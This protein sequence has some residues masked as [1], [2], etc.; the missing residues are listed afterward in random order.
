MGKFDWFWNAMGAKSA[1]HEKQSRKIVG[2]AQQQAAD[3]DSLS[4]DKLREHARSSVNPSGEITDKST[5]LAALATA[6]SR[7][8]GLRPYDVQSQ[9]VLRLLTGDVIHM[10]TGEGKTLV[11][12]MAATGFALSGKRVHVVTVNDYLARRDAEWMRPLVESFGLEVAAVTES[13]DTA[14]RRQAYAADVVYAPVKEL[15]FDVLR[16]NQITSREQAVFQQADVALV[17]EA[18]SVLVD[19]A[20]VPLVLAGTRADQATDPRVTTVVANLKQERDYT[21][22][23]D[24]RTVFLTDDGAATVEKELGIDSLY[25]DEHIG[26]TLVR[27]NLALHAKALLIRDIHYLV[28]DGELKL[29]DTAKGRV[30]DLQRWPDGL[31]AAVE[32]KEGLKVTEGGRILDTL[33]IQE[34]MR[35]YPQLCGMTGTAVEATDQLRE[36]YGLYVS[37]IAPN[38]APQRFDEADRVYATVAEKTQALLDE[39]ELLHAQKQPVLIG[40]QDVA[41]SESLDAALTERGINAQVLN[42]KN[43]AEEA[44]IIAEAGMPGRVTVST[45]MAGRG[46]DIKLGGTDGT[47]YQE[48]K[49]AGG[50][51]VLGTT[52]HRSSRLDNQLRGRAGRQGDPGLSLFF[53]SLED[54]VVISGGAGESV[55]AQ[56][57]GN[58]RI[59]SGRIV[60]FI[61]HCQRVTEAQLLEIHSQTWKYNKLLADQREIIDERRSSLLDTDKAWTELREY[62]PERA[63]ELVAAGLADDVLVQAS[64]EIM[65]YHLDLAWA[66]HLEHM[67]D[68]RE[69]IH[70]RAIARETPID[71]YHRIAVREFKEIVRRGVEAARE[72][73]REVVIDNAGAHLSEGG[74]A[75]PSATW[76]YMVSDNPLAGSGN[77]ALSGI[78]NLFR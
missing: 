18:D 1:K 74:L 49:D 21:I 39:I 47:H 15:G 78:G 17:D 30:A 37:E 10:A 69:S 40:T 22:G 8:L 13:M 23:T 24:G 64:R 20:L 35:R 33:T 56:P 31:Q 67:D 41:E 54:D 50:L 27:V 36:F 46:T 72:S 77:S 34:L 73:F 70:L 14:Q 4:D 43:D 19:E 45:Q 6:S 68:V 7:K 42:A 28:H 44:A 59:D 75:R 25:S 5:F 26:S 2:Q 57:D 58:G 60:D 12:A 11:G 48:V 62:E 38:K 32:E 3:F 66:D 65:L 61:A 71:E 51:A 52:R 53:V 76:T 29:I 55:E 16:D 63:A 9:A